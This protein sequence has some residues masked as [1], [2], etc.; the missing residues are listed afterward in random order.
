MS[1]RTFVLGLDAQEERFIL[2]ERPIGNTMVLVSQ[3]LSGNAI[4][5]DLLGRPF[6]N[7]VLIQIVVFSTKESDSVSLDW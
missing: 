7:V 1:L 6:G 3:D 5:T 2:P 4:K